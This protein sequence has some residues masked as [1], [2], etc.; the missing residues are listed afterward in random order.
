MAQDKQPFYTKTG[1]WRLFLLVALPIHLWA[2]L[3]ALRDIEAMT[4][5]S[6]FY[7]ALGFFAYILLIALAESVLTYVVIVLLGG[8]LPRRW[9]VRQRVLSSSLLSMGIAF[10]IILYQLNYWSDYKK[11]FILNF[12]LHSNHILRYGSVIITVG[13]VLI[14]AS[15]IVPIILVDRFP[16][17]VD[18]YDRLAE[19][20]TLLSSVY[21]IMDI[22]A[23]FLVLYRNIA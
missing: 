6:S 12:I 3:M 16:R 5:R 15:I 17:F 7:D 18:W 11:G 20:F 4:R 9:S 10:W 2:M 1:L 21:I 8:L 19:R 13:T 23:V 14:L 22:L